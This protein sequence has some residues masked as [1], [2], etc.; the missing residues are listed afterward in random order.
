[1]RRLRIPNP[2]LTKSEKTY[3]DLDYASGIGTTLTVLNNYGFANYDIAIIG[4]VGEEKSE[5]KN[6]TSQTGNTVINIGGVLKFSHNKGCI[7]YRYE[8]D[9]VEIY[10]YRASAWTLISTSN[11]QW[12]KRETI[13]VDANG[14]STDA[15]RYRFVNSASSNT[16]DYSPTVL[17]T[18][19]TRNQVGYM[20]REVRRILGDAERRF[21]SDEEIIRQFNRAQ[22]VVKAIRPNWWF[23]RKENSQMTT[24]ATTRKYGLLTY[25]SD[26]NYID[27]VRYKY[28]SGNVNNIYHLTKLS[29]V[30]LD[31]LVR[32]GNQVGDN[33]PSSY[34]IEPP[35]SVDT[36]GYLTIDKPPLTSG[37]GTF[38]IRYFKNM[39]DLDDVAD[40][41]DI[42]I[43]SILEDFAL[44]Y[45]F[46]VKGDE[47]RAGIYERRFWG[48]QA[49]HNVST[50]DK[51]REK[52]GLRLL[53]LMQN[54]KGRAV[55]QPESL[56]S[57]RGRS[58]I[59]KLY[60]SS[61]LNRD[62]LHTNYY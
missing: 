5:S 49:G 46:R 28:L 27:S 35:D 24:V 59:R 25:L 7:V 60:H 20:I 44:A 3:L 32:D 13:Y 30:E 42:P 2:D 41:T 33:W 43:P 34:T 9:Q 12:D 16:S 39:T 31:Y 55:G 29:L 57:W 8:F 17:A 14:L 11:L 50:S 47:V 53:E 51:S 4:E 62:E 15:Y 56:K 10:R 54:A 1:M 26:M 36:V 38:Y 45:G 21:V 6:V 37:L 58:A 23:L 22:D 52:T 18:G 40:A 61:S 19:F 48:P